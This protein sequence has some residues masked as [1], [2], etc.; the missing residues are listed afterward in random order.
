MSADVISLNA[1]VSACEKGGQWAQA[2]TLLC[3]VMLCYGMLCHAMLRYA[4]RNYAMLCY[5]P[6]R[7]HHHSILGLA[8][9]P[10][11]RCDVL[12]FSISLSIA[13]SL[14]FG[15]SDIGIE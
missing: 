11:M 12:H 2:F 3:Y 8:Q 6:Q 10:A 14:S 15:R 9:K 5:A 1:A 7:G 13:L 4:M